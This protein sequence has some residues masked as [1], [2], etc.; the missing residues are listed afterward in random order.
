MWSCMRLFPK[1]A[2][3]IGSSASGET[4]RSCFGSPSALAVTRS[5]RVPL[6]A[7]RLAPVAGL[8]L[9]HVLAH[10]RSHEA[11]A[12]IAEQPLSGLLLS[13][14]CACIDLMWSGVRYPSATHVQGLTCRL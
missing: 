9:P 3:S 4:L 12:P 13:W 10:S 14:E 1:S 11:A 8:G 7:T 2:S 6:V 5:S